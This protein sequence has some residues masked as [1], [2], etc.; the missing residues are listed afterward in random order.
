MIG[1]MLVGFVFFLFCRLRG[2]LAGKVVS[3]SCFYLPFLFSFGGVF[4]LPDFGFC[5]LAIVCFFFGCCLIFSS[6]VPAGCG[7][8]GTAGS[9]LLA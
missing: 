6:V 9:W 8:S 7:A 4:V 5:M 2:S 1:L 3:W